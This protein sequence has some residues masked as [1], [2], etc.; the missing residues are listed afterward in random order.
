MRDLLHGGKQGARNRGSTTSSTLP[1]L[2]FWLSAVRQ[3]VSEDDFW[4]LHF[5]ED[6][7]ARAEDLE[8][9]V[10]D[11]VRQCCEVC[12]PSPTSQSPRR[13][14]SRGMPCRKTS[15]PI[16]R[17]SLVRRQLRLQEEEQEWMGKIIE[18]CWLALVQEAAHKS[19]ISALAQ[20]RPGA[21]RS[22]S[23]TT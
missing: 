20:M 19:K 15:Q 9:G 23:L 1:E 10:K 8:L 6:I 4:G 14:S 5:W 17:G 21:L 7:E 13:G 22:R 18:A 2:G 11:L 3:A 12:S 16:K